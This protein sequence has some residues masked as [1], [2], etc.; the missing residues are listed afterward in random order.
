VGS[1]ATT[2]LSDAALDAIV[3]A[4][5][6]LVVGLQSLLI[7]GETGEVDWSAGLPLALGSAAGAYVA[8]RLITRASAKAWVY[9]FLVLVVVLSIV[10]LVMV[11]STKFLQHA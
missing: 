7:V 3:I 6:L 8:A 5:L 1:L 11:D 4:G 9:R 10:H 2:R